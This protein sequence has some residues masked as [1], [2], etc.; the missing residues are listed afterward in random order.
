MLERFPK[1]F[2]TVY[3]H[4]PLGVPLHAV[5]PSVTPVCFA[6][7]WTGA[8]PEAHGIRKYEKPVLT[9]D[10][11]YDALIRAGRKPVIIAVAN[12]SMERIFRD[13]PMDYYAEPNDDAVMARAFEILEARKHDFVIVYQIGYDGTS[14]KTHPYSDEA[15]GQMHRKIENFAAVADKMNTC[16]KGLRRMISFNPDHG[17]HTNLADGRG[18]HG[19]DIPQDMDVHHFFGFRRD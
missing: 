10:T 4:A 8:Q 2:E 12:C 3:R 5:M 16:W 15:I 17:N 18:T 11:I 9:C 7:M 19:M 6:S 1:P 13:R 14:H